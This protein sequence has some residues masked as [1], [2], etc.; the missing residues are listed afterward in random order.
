M[1]FLTPGRLIAPGAQHFRRF[2]NR[3]HL[4]DDILDR[5]AALFE[6]ADHGGDIFGQGIARS[7]NVSSF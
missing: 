5:K 1:I 4:T 6:P 7:E 2:F 3:N